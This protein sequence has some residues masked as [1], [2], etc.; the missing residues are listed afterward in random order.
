MAQHLKVDIHCL[1]FPLAKPMHTVFGAVTSRPA[2]ILRIEDHEGAEGWGEIWCNFPQPGADYRARLAEAVIPGALSGVDISR[3]GTAFTT[4]RARLHHLALQA[5]EP[6]PADQIASGLDIALHDL[7]ARREGVALATFLG[8]APRALP[9]YASGIDSRLGLEMVAAARNAGF[10]AFKMRVGFRGLDT[11]AA[12]GDVAQTLGDGERLMIDANQAWEC[13]EATGI[14]ASLSGLPLRWV[15]EPLPVDAPS[16]D[17]KRVAGA[18]SFPIAGGENMRSEGEFDTAIAGDVFDV[19]QPD[20]CKWG[21]LSKCAAIARSVIGTGK[22]Y[23]PHY[24]GGGVGTS[25]V[26]GRRRRSPRSRRQRKR[27]PG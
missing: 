11:A 3:P 12:V 16:S 13:E 24:L 18:S 17:W 9:A 15:E 14:L 27:S 26:G 22:T 25:L 10:R 8:G 23:C 19:I 21:G 4:I 6:G 5:G 1:R 2:L 7:A 20:I